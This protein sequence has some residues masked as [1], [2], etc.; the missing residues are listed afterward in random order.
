MF[1]VPFKQSLK[2][3]LKSAEMPAVIFHPLLIEKVHLLIKT[4]FNLL[5]FLVSCAIRV[6]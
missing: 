5:V 6:A 2:S 3:A 4:F 1:H